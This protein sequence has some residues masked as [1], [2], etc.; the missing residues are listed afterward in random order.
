MLQVVVFDFD[1]VIADTETAHFEMLRQIIKQEG[2]DIDWQLYC[3]KYMAYDDWGCFRQLL[4]D[5]GREASPEKI[6]ALVSEKKANFARFLAQNTVIFPG[7]RELLSELTQ[8][9]IT[10]SLCS[11]AFR[12]EIEYALREEGL[13]DFFKVIVAADDVRI[14][15]P[16]PQS[17]R[18]CL[19]KIK[20]LS[21]P[22]QKIQAHQC[23][24]IEDSVGGIKAAKAAGL[25]CLAVA[26]SYPRDQLS[27]ADLVV[28]ELTRVNVDMLRYMVE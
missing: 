22:K 15:K 9:N 2:I 5:C 14:S 27:E 26:N 23:V 24:A 1:G 25:A 12:S 3:D 20:R 7:V 8:E 28:D 19:S 16:D 11:G 17:Y 21:R 18:T 4:V 6:S 10:I 13:R